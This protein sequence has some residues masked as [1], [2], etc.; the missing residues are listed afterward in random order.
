MD[1][2]IDFKT[3]FDPLDY[4]SQAVRASQVNN[5]K[6]TKHPAGAYFQAIPV[7]KI[8]GLSAIPYKQ[9]EANG[10]FKID[11]LHLSAI[12]DFDKYLESKAE[13]RQLAHIE[14]DW[15]LLLS[16]AV[17]AKL[18]QIHTRA[19]LLFKIKP[20]SVDELADCIAL[21]RPAKRM[22][23]DPYIKMTRDERKAF[24]AILYA[25]PED[26]SYYYKRPHSISYAVTIV[27]Q[28]HLI[29]AGL[30]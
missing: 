23:A 14:P 15:N 5:E 11:F 19:E 20:Q 24:R 16:A 8:S 9:A 29:K 7:D 21:I 4:F 18:F 26:G 2:D 3:D 27:I 17:V 1:V 12:D 28:L 30:L 22:L 6:L 25:E 10:Y 13:V